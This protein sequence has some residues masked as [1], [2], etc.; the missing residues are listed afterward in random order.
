MQGRE[1]LAL[2]RKPNSKYQSPKFHFPTQTHTR[3]DFL[4]PDESVAQQTA[5][6]AIHA[7]SIEFRL[8]DLKYLKLTHR[9][10]T[11][12]LRLFPQTAEDME[13]KWLLCIL[14]GPLS[15][16]F[17]KKMKR[18]KRGNINGMLKKDK[19]RLTTAIGLSHMTGDFML[20]PVNIHGAVNNIQTDRDSV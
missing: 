6:K 7:Q 3:H 14:K 20:L 13:S 15:T 17:K 4:C 12:G 18:E 5:K 10:E 2:L 16:I 11:K 8:S 19:K 1:K 9:R